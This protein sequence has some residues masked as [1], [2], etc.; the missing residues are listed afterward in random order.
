[1]KKML[2]QRLAESR[3][4][5]I[6]QLLNAM[7][8]RRMPDSLLASALRDMDME[9]TPDVLAGELAWLERQGLVNLEQTAIGQ[10]IAI[11]AKG[12]QHE[13]GVIVEPGVAR[14]ALG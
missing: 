14:P 8:A 7:E 12:D 11:T 1:M 6:L 5:I 4:L 10:S 13:R 2:A 9:T 3:R